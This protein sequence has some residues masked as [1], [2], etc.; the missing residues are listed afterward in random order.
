MR[1]T[2]AAGGVPDTPGSP[3]SRADTPDAPVPTNR[4]LQ[5]RGQLAPRTLA[6]PDPA[7]WPTSS[8]D[9]ELIAVGSAG[10]ESKVFPDPV[11]RSTD[12]RDLEWSAEESTGAEAEAELC[13]AVCSAFAALIAQVAARAASDAASVAVGLTVFQYLPVGK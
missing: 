8:G 9:Q 10:T 11:P 7:S 3:T 2:A 1:T 5:G 12:S 4:L 6:L 13:A